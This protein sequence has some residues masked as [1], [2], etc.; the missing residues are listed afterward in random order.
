MIEYYRGTEVCVDFSALN[1]ASDSQRKIFHPTSR[2]NSD[3]HTGVFGVSRGQNEVYQ[4]WMREE[5]E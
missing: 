1:V 3:R 4:F 2:R 5:I